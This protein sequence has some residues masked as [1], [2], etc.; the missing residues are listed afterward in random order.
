MTV[1]NISLANLRER[2]LPTWRGSNPRP[3]D[4]QLDAHPAEPLR[5]A[6]VTCVQADVQYLF[7]NIFA[8]AT[9]I[10]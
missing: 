3:P 10:F 8:M 9:D 5:P 4:R 6:C 2:M 1:E 7:A